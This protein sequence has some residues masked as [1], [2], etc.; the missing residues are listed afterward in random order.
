MVI[1]FGEKFIFFILFRFHY[2][3]LIAVKKTAFYDFLLL[4]NELF[5]TFFCWNKHFFLTFFFE[6]NIFFHLKT[7]FKTIKRLS[8]YINDYLYEMIYS[9]NWYSILQEFTW[10]HVN[11]R[12]KF[13]KNQSC[14]YSTFK[15]NLLVDGLKL[16]N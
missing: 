7:A 15:K 6:K 11:S 16:K 9:M 4:K 14:S 8:K 1:I 3:S 2:Q 10:N 12:E 13:S 5:L